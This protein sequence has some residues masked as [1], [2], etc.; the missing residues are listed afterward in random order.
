MVAK[1][2]MTHGLTAAR[3]ATAAEAGL[4]ETLRSALMVQYQPQDPLVKL[5]IDRIARIAAKLQ[6]L[7]QIEDAAFELAQENALPTVHDIVAG[8]G[9][10]DAEAQAQAV[11]ILQGSCPKAKLGLDDAALAQLCDEIRA[12][13]H[14]VRTVADVEALLPKT[15]AFIHSESVRHETADVGLQLQAIVESLHPPSPSPARLRVKNADFAPD[16]EL[17]DIINSGMASNNDGMV[18]VRVRPQNDPKVLA[19]GLQD[20]LHALLVL[21]RHRQAVQDIVQRYPARRAL[22]LR[23]AMPPA[24]EADRLMRYHV[25]LDRQLSKCMGELLQMDAMRP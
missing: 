22:L 7:Q 11:R 15:Y 24:D 19:Q 1:N 14:R 10:A 4:V 6:R 8:M 9:P 21:E 16:E 18:W 13:G 2:A 20:D 5:Q 3:P 17:M 23:A 25:A 12:N